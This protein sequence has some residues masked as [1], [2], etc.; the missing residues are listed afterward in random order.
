MWYDGCICES[1]WPVH[2]QGSIAR[3]KA[4]MSILTGLVM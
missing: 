1:G 2:G 4:E 3:A